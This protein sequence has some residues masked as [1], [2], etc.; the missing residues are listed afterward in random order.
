MISLPLLFKKTK[1]TKNKIYIRIPISL[2]KS[3]INF[4]LYIH[5]RF[6]SAASENV[7]KL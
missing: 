1:R 5:F 3:S 7:N 4:H 2:D 6:K